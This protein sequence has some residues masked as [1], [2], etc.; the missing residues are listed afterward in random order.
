MEKLRIQQ[1]V[2]VEGRYDAAKLTDIVDAPILTT[3]GF[4]IFKDKE[5]QLLLKHLAQ[6]QGL[7]LLTDADDAGFKIRKFITDIAG[8]S[9]V[10]Q[11]YIPAVQGKEK[12]K[13]QASK[14]GT[15]G[16]EGIPAEV[17][18][19]ALLTAGASV[20]QQR[21]GRQITYTD[22]FEWGLSGGVGSADT[23]RELLRRVGLPPRL[24]KKALCEVLNR[25]YTYEEFCDVLQQKPVLFWDFHGTLVEHDPIWYDA[26]QEIIQQLFPEKMV[27][28]K[29]IQTA[30]HSSKLPWWNS[31]SGEEQHLKTPREWWAEFEQEF[32]WIFEQC[33]FLPNEAE[34]IAKKM[35]AK[36]IQPK[37]HRLKSDALYVL[38]QFQRKGYQQYLLSNNFPETIQVVQQLGLAPYF[39]G[40]IVS[41]L[42]GYDKPQEG[43]FRT[44]LEQAGNPSKAYMIGDNPID[45]LQGCKKVGMVAVGVANAANSPQAD[46]SAKTLTELL[47]VLPQ[48]ENRF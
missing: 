3:N 5:Q 19:Q 45:D 48:N 20:R 44:A 36:I 47:E 32:Q 25:M 43:I 18:R 28:S 33:G 29:V 8:E 1:A 12:R 27:E 23:R 40:M 15:L 30:F 14:E 22:L 46:L 42:V 9:N 4:A 17:I 16:V 41:A 39:S 24:S 6:I 35:R 31:V 37:R 10:K 11:A 7:I 34:H 13:T 21:Q 2:V 38:Q 26:A